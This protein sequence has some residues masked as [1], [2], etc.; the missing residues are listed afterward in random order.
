[1]VKCLHVLTIIPCFYKNTLITVKPVLND[2]PK[3][4][5]TKDLKSDGSLM[6]EGAQWHSGRMLDLRREA[7]GSSL[8]GVTALWSLSKTYLS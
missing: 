4:D 6:K 3:I 2:H 8:V 5:K 1:M 7:A